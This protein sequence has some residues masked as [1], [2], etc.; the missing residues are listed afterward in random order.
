MYEIYTITSG[1]TMFDIAN[2][3][4][5]TEEILNQINGLY[6]SV[7]LSP[8]MQIVVPSNK[9]QAFWYYTVAKGDN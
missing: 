4:G 1:D 8:G 6:K 3:F 9:N 5:T 2:K 7:V